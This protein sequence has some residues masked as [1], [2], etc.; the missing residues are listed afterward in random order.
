MQPA[1]RPV[2][3]VGA[4]LAGSEAAL[5]MAEKGLPVDLFEMRPLRMT[6]AHATG[7]PAELICSNSFKSKM[8]PSAHA[9]L[10]EELSLLGSPLLEVARGT[11]VP[12]GSALAVD[13]M[14][15]AAGVD[16][17]IRR[18]P[19]INFTRRECESRPEGYA[20]VV[21]AAGPLVSESLAAWLGRTCSSE[22]LCFYDAIAPIVSADSLD[23][24][25]VFQASRHEKEE[26]DYLNCP[27]TRDE[28][29]IFYDALRESDRV[30]AH[31][32]EEARF[33]EA[34]L[35]IEVMAERGEDA[36]RFGPMKPI[37]LIDPRTGRRPF[38]VCQLRKENEAG[39]C[40][41]LVGFQTRLTIPAQREVFRLIPGLG[42]AE[43]LRLGSIH[44]NTYIDSPRLLSADLSFRHD[45]SLFCAGQLCG[46]E[47]YTENIATGHC[48]ALSVQA[49]LRGIPFEPPPAETAL[50]SLVRH[51]TGS[52]IVPFTPTNVHF[53]LLP[54]IA[55]NAGRIRKKANKELLCSRALEQCAAW[56]KTAG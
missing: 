2:A 3:V 28:Y 12:A 25:I 15:F 26:A 24:S 32:F 42:K 53:G 11:A 51:V 43:F 10:K 17:R 30:I 44:R 14:L 35:P 33:F 1:G 34:C 50:G 9:L 5:V 40:F 7:L 29:R 56:V 48:A 19:L 31:A 18:C 54:P 22:S 13:R 52:P 47:G 49:K 45:P 39:T 8:L 21:I 20:A 36:L 6:P 16:A 4:G 23:R 46:S 55:G 38:A 41:N 37:G 27:F